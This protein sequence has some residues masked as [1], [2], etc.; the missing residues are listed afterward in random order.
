MTAPRS[1]LTA[2]QTGYLGSVGCNLIWGV[3]PL[4]F[5]YLVAFPMAEIVAHRALWAAVFL[6]VILLITGGLRGLSAAVAG[7]PV[8]LSLV[9]GAALVTVNWTAYLYAVDTGQIVQSALGYFLYPLIWT[10]SGARAR[11]RADRGRSTMPHL[12]FRRLRA[13]PAPL[14]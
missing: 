13:R 4:Y 8:F 5:A 11:T 14:H 10:S 9:A 7:W 1:R 3:A 12:R 6:F 2:T